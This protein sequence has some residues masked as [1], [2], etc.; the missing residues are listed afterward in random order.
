METL[1]K[2]NE[3]EDACYTKTGGK[4][5]ARLSQ[6]IEQKDTHEYGDGR[7]K[8]DRV[9]GTN[10]DQTSDFKLTQHES[11]QAKGTVKGDKSP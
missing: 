4:E 5:P 8:S 3:T 7:W 2:E 9:V 1:N 10:P 11:D 6:R